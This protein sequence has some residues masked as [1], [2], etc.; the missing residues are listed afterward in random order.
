M[1]PAVLPSLVKTAKRVGGFRFGPWR[2]FT[3][4]VYRASGWRFASLSIAGLVVEV[5]EGF[6]TDL[7]SAPW[8]ARPF[9]PLRHLAVAALIHDR[10]RQ[11]YPHLSLEA[12]DALMLLVMIE[13]GV[14]E[15]WRTIVWLAVRTNN[16]RA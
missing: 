1:T 9:M 16:N 8:W 7:V 5:P 2:L 14:P 13:T 11:A 10:L 4:P 6:L 3:R 15:P 12:I